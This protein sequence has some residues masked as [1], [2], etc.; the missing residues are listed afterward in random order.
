MFALIR[1]PLNR[2]I[3]GVTEMWNP[4]LTSNGNDLT[5]LI[6][7]SEEELLKYNTYDRHVVP[8]HWNFETYTNITLFKFEHLHKVWE[9]LGMDDPGIHERNH[10]TMGGLQADIKK[11]VKGKVL[12][13]QIMEAYKIDFE[14]WK[15]AK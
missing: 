1:H 6:E 9:W 7:I 12:H 8:Q 14:L 11:V 2:W 3:S 13:S 10:L 15:R 5:P 4:I